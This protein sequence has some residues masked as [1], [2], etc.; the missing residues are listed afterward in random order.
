MLSEIY[1]KPNFNER[2]EIHAW[3]T[4]ITP[5]I[6]NCIPDVWLSAQEIT[7]AEKYQNQND[8]LLF[9][10]SHAFMR[11]IIS[12]YKNIPPDKVEYQIDANGKP[13]IKNSGGFCFNLSHSGWMAAIV[14]SQDIDIG[15]DVELIR[16]IEDAGSIVK[17]NFS[18]QELRQFNSEKEIDSVQ[19]FFH[20]WT[21]KESYLKA[22][23]VGLSSRLDSFS[24]NIGHPAIVLSPDSENWS[25]FHLDL[26]AEYC[27]AVAARQNK[28]KLKLGML[29]LSQLFNL[30][31]GLNLQKF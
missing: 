9:K 31:C 15:I 17:R 25:L 4:L 11:Y 3:Y 28:V 16:P 10:A 14:V 23:G 29:E 5:E 18:E 7:R 13:S 19:A 1:I 20:L 27:G 12:V 6:A 30:E 24:V 8:R 22:S 26:P 2:N 21:R